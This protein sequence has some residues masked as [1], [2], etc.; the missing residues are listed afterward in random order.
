M[1]P[2]ELRCT[3]GHDI[4]P[5]WIVICGNLGCTGNILADETEASPYVA[6]LEAVNTELLEALRK[7]NDFFAHLADDEMPI[8]LS[9]TVAE[10]IAKAT[11]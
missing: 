1:K 9:L 5:I 7:C 3:N 11:S 10:A 2:N 4:E 8:G 6:R